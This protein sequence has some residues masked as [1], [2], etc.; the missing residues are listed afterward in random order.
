MRAATLLALLMSGCIATPA[1]AALPEA[2]YRYR[3]TLVREAHAAW[4]L[5]APVATFAAQ[6]HQESHWRSNVT[7]SAGAAGMTQVMP[8]TA[9]WLAS[10]EPSLSPATPTNPQ[11]SLRAMLVYDRWLWQRIKARDDCQRMAK[12]LRAYNGGLGWLRRDEQLATAKG[13]DPDINFGQLD[14]VNAG[15]SLP[16]WRENVSYPRLILLSHEPR[17][18]AAGFGGGVCA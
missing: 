1:P 18:I 6:V 17:Y 16:A 2:S 3:A 9:R 10:V 5:S 7:S 8:D 12:A 13:I 14:T 15:R 11:W 4:G